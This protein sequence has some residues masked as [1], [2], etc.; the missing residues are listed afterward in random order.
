MQ[1]RNRLGS[2]ALGA[3]TLGALFLACGGERESPGG[4]PAA[5]PAAPKAAAVQELSAQAKRCLDLVEAKRY[6][7]ALDPCQ[8]AVAE[9]ASADVQRAY[10][11]AKAAVQQE[12]RSAAARS[13][14]E[15][16]SGKPADEAAKGAASDA[17]RGL[18]GGQTEP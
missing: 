5:A 17:L 1:L 9:A 4:G 12:A 6:A 13:A 8:R 14:A 2:A 16:L 7:E 10:D 15:S 18:T 3:V 11:E